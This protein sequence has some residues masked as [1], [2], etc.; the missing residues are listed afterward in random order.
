M[1]RILADSMMIA[2]RADRHWMRDAPPSDEKKRRD[3]VFWQGRHWRQ[4]DLKDL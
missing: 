3:R 1:L 2:A 4:V